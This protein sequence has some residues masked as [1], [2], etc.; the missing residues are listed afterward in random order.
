MDKELTDHEGVQERIESL[1]KQLG[2]VRR[3]STG[4]VTI[5]NNSG[6]SLE[7]IKTAAYVSIDRYID[8]YIDR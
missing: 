3:S 5:C 1:Q 4:S 6:S 2:K 7:D 8:R